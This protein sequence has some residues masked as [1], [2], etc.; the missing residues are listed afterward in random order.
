M[1]GRG[2]IAAGLCLGL[3][4]AAAADEWRLRSARLHADAVVGYGLQ[5]KETA[6]AR[7]TVTPTLSFSRGRRWRADLALR[8]ELSGGEA[9]L[10]TLESF[11]D[12]SRPVVDGP[13]GRVEIDEAVI[14]WRD[15]SRSLS[16]GKQVTAWGALDGFR[17]SDA[18][19]PVRLREFVLTENR[20][21]RISIWSARARFE[22]ASTGVDLVYAPD[23]TV[24]QLAETGAAFEARAPRF[25]G[26]LPASAATPP[27]RVSDRSR[28]LEDAVYAAR[29]TRGL[30]GGEAGLSAISGPDLDPLLS[31]AAGP[32]GAEVRLD[33]ERRTLIGATYVRGAGAIVA[34]FDAAW[35]P[36][37]PVNVSPAPQQLASG[38]V[39]RVII[40]AGGDW[41]AP[42]DLFV[43]LQIVADH[44]A[45][46]PAGLVRAQTDWIATAKL[47]R[48]LDHEQT[49]L[50]LEWLGSLSEGDGVVRPRIERRISDHSGVY[51]GL[52]WLYGDG[53]GI[54]G[55]FEDQSR[56]Y[57]GLTLS[58]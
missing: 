52:D 5:S 2:A 48:R 38:E 32:A 53:D 29:L 44:V 4:A 20:P 9:G 56:V 22:L 7:L 27:I 41:E 36:D 49:T 10:G 13:D 55:Q 6:L 57:V 37:Q 54:F 3:S 16:L 15:R 8:G 42:A 43:N 12:L 18:V 28:Y 35:I 21:D 40:G 17:V 30:F 11:S 1:I 14:R 39:S 46:A 50:K 25:R 34:R 24:N 47:I 31:P 33:H 19:N 58:R 51:A 26:G 23:P 45:D